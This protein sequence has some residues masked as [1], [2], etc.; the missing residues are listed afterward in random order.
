MNIFQIKTKPHGN[1]RLNDFVQGEFLAIG[2]PGIGNLN[3]VSKDEV[4]ER[5]DKAYDYESSR[6]LGN[7]LG[8]V[9]AFVDTM[10]EGDLVLFQGHVNNVYIVKVGPYEYVEKY[11]NAIGMAH[12]RKFELIKVVKKQ[13]LNSKVQE[14]LRNRSA[15]TKFKYPIEDAELDLIN[16]DMPVQYDSNLYVD[17]DEEI[18]QK[19]MQILID[20]LD[21]S[22][23]EIRFKAAVE[24]LRYTK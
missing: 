10:T 23:E 6:S 4:R 8:N 14:L 12:Q 17:V 20:G 16:I 22:S 2:W 18:I 3:E 21:S 24:L 5:L 9:W 11:D 1:E 13:Q 15:I 7:D 19:A